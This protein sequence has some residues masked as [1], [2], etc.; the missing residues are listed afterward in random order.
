MAQFVCLFLS[1][2]CGGECTV[3]IDD[4]PTSFLSRL[5]GGEFIKIFGDKISIFLSRLCGGEL[6]AQR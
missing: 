4:G 1:R 2:L 3:W 6:C 5:C